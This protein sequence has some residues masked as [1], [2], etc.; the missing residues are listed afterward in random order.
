MVD[1]KRNIL[2]IKKLSLVRYL[3]RLN[4]DGHFT[5]VNELYYDLL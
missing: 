3:L 2:T 1:F 4:A 5:F